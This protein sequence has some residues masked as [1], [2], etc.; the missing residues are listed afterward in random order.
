MGLKDN[1]LFAVEMPKGSFCD[2]GKQAETQ[3]VI[4]NNKGEAKRL[5][6]EAKKAR[7][8]GSKASDVVC[9]LCVA[10]L[11]AVKGMFVS[12]V[13]K[14][15][16]IKLDR[17]TFDTACLD[18]GKEL[19]FGVYAHFHEASGQAVCVE[20]GAK[21]GW[22][23]KARATS[24]VKMLELKEDIRALRKR[25]KVESEG[26]YL[27]EEKV[28]LH[29]LAATYTELEKQITATISKLES[30]LNAVATPEEKTILLGLE[31]GIHELQDL[32]LE[33]K[34]E[35]ETRLFLLDRAERR[36]KMVEKIG[37]EDVSVEEEIDEIRHAEAAQSE[38]PAR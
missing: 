29:K 21:R 17:L 30:Y 37:P 5:A 16:P 7:A 1:R 14:Y 27:L 15:S 35:F 2:C 34:K 3:F 12:E 8:L 31:R 9:G 25:W 33:I 32:A 18:C 28:D 20:C 13:L 19:K 22:T 24:S 4:T 38:V 23:D 36:R 10:N 26:L 6:T 11:I